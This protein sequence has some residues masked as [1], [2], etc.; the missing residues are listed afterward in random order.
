MIFYL[1]ISISIIAETKASVCGKQTHKADSAFRC[2]RCQ[3]NKNEK[4]FRKTID[5]VLE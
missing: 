5:F 4:V 2:N 1:L 3:K